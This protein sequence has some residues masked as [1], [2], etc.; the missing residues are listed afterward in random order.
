[1]KFL[2]LL[3]VATYISHDLQVTPLEASKNLQGKFQERSHWLSEQQCRAFFARYL[4][5]KTKGKGGKKKS[6]LPEEDMDEE[7]IM[8][9]LDAHE[10]AQYM[11][12]VENA[13]AN[14]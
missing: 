11:E 3:L 8:A 9:I 7:E 5:S 14:E 10:Q 6:T 13:T 1:M 2:F 12:N 4:R